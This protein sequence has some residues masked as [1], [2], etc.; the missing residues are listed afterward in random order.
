MTLITPPQ[1]IFTGFSLLVG[2]FACLSPGL[3][4]SF[5]QNSLEGRWGMVCGKP[6][7]FWLGRIQIGRRRNFI[8]PLIQ[9]CESGHFY[10]FLFIFSDLFR[11]W[12]LHELVQ[13]QICIFFNL[14]SCNCRNEW[15]FVAVDAEAES[16]NMT[17]II[18]D[19]FWT[20][21]NF[22]SGFSG[23]L[24]SIHQTLKWRYLVQL[25]YSLLFYHA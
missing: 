3:L 15:Y 2:L 17:F 20:L 22:Y 11:G 14:I 10:I 18:Y 8:N 16:I 5:P 6:I 23:D 13:K 7:Q 12:Y 4:N 1:D 24:L 25:L 21:K 19:L 9:H